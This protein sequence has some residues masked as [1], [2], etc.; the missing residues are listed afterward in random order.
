MTCVETFQGTTSI[1]IGVVAAFASWNLKNVSKIMRKKFPEAKILILADNDRHL[2][3]ANNKN[4]G[5][6]DA[7]IASKE[8]GGMSTY[9]EPNF[10]N[11]EP[12]KEFSDWNDL[13]REFGIE[14]VQ[15]QLLGFL[16]EEMWL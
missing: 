13:A 12:L 15:Q 10:R 14:E 9:L 3:V 1:K 4:K 11:K 2:E 16:R 8:A 7:R 6:E 5:V